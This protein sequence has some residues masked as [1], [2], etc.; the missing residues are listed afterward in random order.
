LL[1]NHPQNAA[2]P[3]PINDKIGFIGGIAIDTHR[4]LDFYS[5]VMTDHVIEPVWDVEDDEYSFLNNV[6][7]SYLNLALSFIFYLIGVVVR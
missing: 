5:K 2:Y 3:R 7:F 4:F 6:C 1:V